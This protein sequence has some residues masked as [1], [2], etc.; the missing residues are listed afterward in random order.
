MTLI[1][2]TL[3]GILAQRTGLC[4]VKA[5]EQL[6]TRRPG[7]LAIILGC[8]A[9]FWL[10]S[11]LINEI[12]MGDMMAR[13]AI[14]WP[15]A[16]GGL[17]FGIAAAFN[18]GCSVSTLSALTRGHLHM[19][20][21]L[22][23]WVLGWWWLSW[24]S[25]DI[26]YPTLEPATLP[27]RWLVIPSAVII[28]LLYLWP[29]ERRRRY[30]GVIAFGAAAGL[31]GILQPHWSPSQLIADITAAPLFV[32]RTLP[33]MERVLIS[34]ALVAGMALATRHHTHQDHRHHQNRG[35]LWLKHLAAGIVMGIGGALALGGNDSQLL[36]ALPAGS[37]SAI[38][39]LGC[40][41]AGIW[42]GLKIDQH[43]SSGS[44]SDP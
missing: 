43:I 21:T 18:Q 28:L 3:L 19:L 2:A 8:G 16:L 11:P 31:L 12:S 17:L 1:L 4:L 10:A 34:A 15:F 36:L 39:A 41:I 20:A 29:A 22:A 40:M 38:L 26:D 33:E 27:P 23:G 44:R 30:A 32:D 25:L 37:P 7:L 6:R 5:V 24:L 42:L 9:W 35:M 14:T 13:H